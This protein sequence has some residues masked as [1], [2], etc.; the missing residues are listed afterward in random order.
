MARRIVLGMFVAAAL[1]ACSPPGAP[2]A[3]PESAPA[4]EAAAPA[5]AAIDLQPITYPLTDA[6]LVGELGCTF[7]DASGAMILVS[8]GY[9]Q[10]TDPG[11]AVVRVGTVAQSLRS[12]TADG[13]DGLVD[14]ATF[15]NDTVSATV[16]N[17]AQLPDTGEQVGYS[18][19]LTA[20]MGAATQTVAGTWTC[21]P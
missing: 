16:T 21:G 2:E 19:Q 11:T 15:A 14:G 18:A 4:T 6:Q 5:A 9:V 12:D 17:G 8:S 13:Y 1:A 7:R 3:A 20:T 10:S